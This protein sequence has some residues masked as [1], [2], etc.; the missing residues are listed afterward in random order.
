MPSRG[1]AD[2]RQRIAHQG[3]DDAGAA[4]RGDA[5][6]R[7]RVA[8]P[9]SRRSGPRRARGDGSGERPMPRRRRRR[10][11]MATNLPSFATYSGSMPSSSHAAATGGRTGSDDSSST[12]VRSLSRASS[13]QTVP[14]PPRVASRNHRVAGTASS[15]HSTRPFSGAVSDTMSASRARSPRASMTAIPWSADRA[16]DE[17]DVTRRPR[18]RPTARVRRGS[19]PRPRSRCTCRRRHRGRPPSCRR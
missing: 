15:R 13:L 6:R 4:D 7:C 8:R 2:A 3:V 18:V 19:R 16:R 1:S 12:T 17:H 9:G 5:A 14:T 11:T 10:G